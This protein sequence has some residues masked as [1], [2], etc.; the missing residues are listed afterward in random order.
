MPR[1]PAPPST[2]DVLPYLR[3]CV[4]RSREIPEFQVMVEAE[5]EVVGRFGTAFR[6]ENLGSLPAE[7]VTDFLREKVN[8]HWYGLERNAPKI[9]RDMPALRDG[10]AILLDDAAP[11]AERWDAGLPRMH[12]V[13]K[14]IASAMLLVVYPAKCGGWNSVSGEKMAWLG[15]IPEP[16]QR[17]KDGRTYEQINLILLDLADSLGIDLWEL[18]GIWHL[19]ALDHDPRRRRMNQTG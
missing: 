11:L 10:M 9:V 13:G 8:R 4:E 17:R 19:V 12:G 15:L 7:T 18:D 14:A 5:Q 16:W 3:R 1:Q 2:A 6:P